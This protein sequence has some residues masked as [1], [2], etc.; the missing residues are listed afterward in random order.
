MRN[1]LGAVVV[2]ISFSLTACGG[3]STSTPAPPQS[4]SPPPAVTIS[5]SPTS[6]NLTVG[7]T[8]QFTSTVQNS[9]NTAVA[10]QVNGTVGGN[11]TVG[12]ISISGLYTAPA[13]IPSPASVTVTAISQADSTKSASAMVTI[14]FTSSSLK[15][16]YVFSFA[17]FNSNGRFSVVGG[18]QADGNGNLTN[19]LEDLNGSGGVFT[20]VPFAGAYAVGPDGRG[21]ATITSSQRTTNF[22]FVLVAVGQAQIVEFDPAENGNG[23]VVQQDTSVLSLTTLAGNWAFFLSGAGPNAETVAD[24]GRFSLDSAGNI[25][26]GVE[27][28]NDGG[29][30]NSNAAFTGTASSVSSNGRG[31]VS[32]SSTLGT[33]NFVFYV[34]SVNQI[35]VIETDSAPSLSGAAFLQ[36]SPNFTNGSLTG[37]YAFLLN[38]VDNTELPLASVGQ[39]A[40]DGSGNITSGVFDENDGGSVV[41]DQAL[42]G[43]YSVSSNGRG[44]AAVSSATLTSNY[45]LYLISGDLVVFVETDSSAIAIG[46]A[47]LQS[48]G[49]FSNSSVSGNY[50]FDVTGTIIGG[51]INAVGQLT[52][53]GTGNFTGVEDVN[54]SNVL[55]SAAPFLGT[56]SVS[57]TGRATAQLTVGGTASNFVFYMASP[58]EIFFVELDAGEVVSGFANKQ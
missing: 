40:A 2:L 32:F 4:P 37:S 34:A 48:S 25:T 47:H 43:S 21:S 52:A 10:W 30:V 45:A 13:T 3:G 39:I 7:Q 58:S 53:N 17:G 38:G 20:N 16:A 9:T 36:Q 55:T 44:T 33:S 23:T 26:L 29:T 22:H 54:E 35:F 31:T 14:Q 41:L 27:D 50:G 6:A 12:T 11:A 28:Y 24:A 8:Q 46:L 18:F 49:P 5:V 1:V 15:G 51:G 19:G 57:A 56:Y 42:T